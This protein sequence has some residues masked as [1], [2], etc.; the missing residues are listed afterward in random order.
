MSRFING[1]LDLSTI[2]FIGRFG[3]RPMHF[4]IS[5]FI[6]LFRTLFCSL[7]SIY[8]ICI[9]T[10][11]NHPKICFFL[12]LVSMI[13]GSQLFL[14][15]FLA[16]LVTRNASER[17]TYLIDKVLTN[18]YVKIGYSWPCISTQGWFSFI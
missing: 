7:F 17:N 6:G 5:R 16:E 18:C 10:N 12:S 1:F 9:W 8:K 13:I 4:W 11:G 15:G 3:K 2:M 14:T